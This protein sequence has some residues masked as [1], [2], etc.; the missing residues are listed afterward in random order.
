MLRTTT[1]FV[2]ALV[3]SAASLAASEA[4]EL[5]ADAIKQLE[6]GDTAAAV[7]QLKNALQ[8]DP[9]HAPSRL[10]LGK[11]YLETGD[12]ASAEKELR[13]ARSLGVDRVQWESAL[14]EAFLEQGKSGDLLSTLSPAENRSP[15]EQ[16]EVLVLRGRALLLDEDYPAADA[17]FDEA[18]LADAQLA[19]AW[20]GKARASQHAGDPDKVR[21]YVSKAL[22][23]D[24][25]SADAY[26]MR[27]HLAM[28]AGD[29][30]AA[31]GDLNTALKLDPDNEAALYQRAGYYAERHEN[32]SA[33]QDI[34]ALLKI[35]PLHPGGHYLKSVVAFQQGDIDTAQQHAGVVL[36]ADPDHARSLV[37]YGVAALLKGQDE[38]A[39]DYLLRAQT[40]GASQQQLNLLVASMYLRTRNYDRVID[41][42]GP[43]A[44][45]S[46]SVQT[47]VLLGSA[48]MAK[49]DEKRGSEAYGRAIELAPTLPELRTQLG[50]S[51]IELGE[52]ERGMALLGS[53]AEMAGDS[54]QPELILVMG[55]LQQG[56]LDKAEKAALALESRR[57]E[58]PQA[59]SMAGVVLLAAKDT[60]GAKQ[61]F[62]KLLEID[63][64]NIGARI[65]RARVALAEREYEVAE[66]SFRAILKQDAANF[67]ALT[68]MLAL[69][70]AA[71]DTEQTEHWAGEL[72]RA[73]PSAVQP[74]LV[75]LDHYLRHGRAREALTLASG[76]ATENTDNP[77]V[78]YHA[79][80]AQLA[81][82][83]STAALGNL[84]RAAEIQTDSAAIGLLLANTLV[85]TGDLTGARK[86]IATVLQ[87]QPDQVDAQALLAAIELRSGNVEKAA[88]IAQQLQQA[89]PDRPEGHRLNGMILVSTGQVQEG[90]VAL[91][92]AYDLQK[93]GEVA[94]ML[95]AVLTRAG[96]ADDGAAVVLDWLEHR[97][98]DITA[99]RELA[100]AYQQR[101]KIAEAAEQYE[102]MLTASPADF[103]ALNNLAWIRFEQGRKSDALALAKK[104]Y[105]AQPANPL[106]MDTYGWMLFKADGDKRDAL[107]VL[108]EAM[109]KSPANADIRYH[110]AVVMAANGQK[111]EAVAELKLLLVRYPAFSDADAARRLLAELGG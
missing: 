83:Q 20:L 39:R 107:R 28:Q 5:Y 61:R 29:K 34:D 101:G 84:R 3:F 106:V 42:L 71:G 86:Q 90:I 41:T 15:R 19:E 25:E 77:T 60:A 94:R 80:R 23:I 79:A 73:A 22:A 48:Y 35:E 100:V 54:I 30:E 67:D 69:A 52:G 17:A 58:D 104:A 31:L 8:N 44:M 12:A 81:N 43:N 27:A 37:I 88:E 49:G 105:E 97:P 87:Q 24:P 64:G 92:R 18:L 102:E 13:R 103:A 36:R 40:A 96:N 26:V 68:G 70:D 47:L 1:I 4:D 2:I 91:R 76:L 11:L 89:H 16:A 56:N 75:L 62:D 51:L 108:K 95:H 66:Q 65:Q 50:I 53:A 110:S 93:S 59:I 32:A 7:I 99:R 72:Q 63:P 98:G 46:D 74:R 33:Q 55:H 111:E 10:K 78:L 82:G 85:N 57:P 109:L 6:A 21:E 9:G 14:G 45:N 38:I